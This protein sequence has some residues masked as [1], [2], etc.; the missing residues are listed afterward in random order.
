MRVHRPSSVAALLFIL[1]VGCSSVTDVIPMGKD[2][3]TVG[4]TMS[5]NFP[6]W[7]EVKGLAYKRSNEYCAGLGKNMVPVK[8]ETH[9]ARGW[10]PLEA[11]VT[12][13]CLASDDPTYLRRPQDA[14]VAR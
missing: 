3:Y 6:S 14:P 4:A 2:T 8:T 12:F 13:Q 11:E 10:T 9:G 7:P 5:G 1:L